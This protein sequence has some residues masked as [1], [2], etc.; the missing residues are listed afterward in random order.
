[1]PLL[2]NLSCPIPP[3]Y[4]PALPQIVMANS[5]VENIYLCVCVVLT[6][7]SSTCCH[8]HNIIIPFGSESGI[9]YHK[10]IHRE[11]TILNTPIGF[12]ERPECITLSFLSILR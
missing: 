7:S 2:Q 11:D 5:M 10:N 6:V 8:K 3:S 12:K 4:C 9:K 1:M